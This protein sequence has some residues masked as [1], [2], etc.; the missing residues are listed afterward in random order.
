MWPLWE[1]KF[2]HSAPP[3]HVVGLKDA[4]V[5]VFAE[6][7]DHEDYDVRRNA[8]FAVAFFG[9]AGRAAIEP[10]TRAE[11]LGEPLRQE[12]LRLLGPRTSTAPSSHQRRTPFDHLDQAAWPWDLHLTQPTVDLDH[13]AP[14]CEWQ[15]AQATGGDLD[16]RIKVPK[17]QFLYYLVE[18]RGV[19]LHGSSTPGI[20]TLMPRSRSWGGGRTAGQPGI[21]AVDH[22]LMAM[23]FGI[24]DRGKVSYM[25]NGTGTR[26]ARTGRWCDASGWLSTSRASSADRSSTR[27]STFFP[28]RPSA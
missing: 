28:Q 20:D 10:V 27:R 11:R 19:V 16:Y 7:L 23:Y 1:S 5:S 8:A 3:Q 12:V 25:S 6:H 22:A 26:S 18:R 4:T 24:V 14:D 9:R 2:A 13:I 21:F 15:W 17:W